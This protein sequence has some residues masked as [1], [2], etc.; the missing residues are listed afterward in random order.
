[1]I[2]IFLIFCVKTDSFPESL[3][4]NREFVE[5]MNIKNNPNFEKNPKGPKQCLS[6]RTSC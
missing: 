1:M 4:I 5:K 3:C 6:I 2:K